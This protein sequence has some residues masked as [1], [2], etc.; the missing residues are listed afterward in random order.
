MREG[1]HSLWCTYGLTRGGSVPTNL[2]GLG[3]QTHVFR[4]GGN[5]L[6]HSESCLQPAVL[7][8]V[9]LYLSLSQGLPGRNHL[10]EGASWQR[11]PRFLFHPCFSLSLKKTSE[12]FFHVTEG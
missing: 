12:L 8:L 5:A 7:S 1:A 11:G 3:D 10:W 4:L 2:M 9:S 6:S